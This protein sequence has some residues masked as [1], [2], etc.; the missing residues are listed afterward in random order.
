MGS[1]HGFREHHQSKF[2]D[3]SLLET[4]F[5]RPNKDEMTEI[6]AA[7]LAS[8]LTLQPFFPLAH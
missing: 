8:G 2:R 3:F 5:F 6:V 4:K 1:T 7:S